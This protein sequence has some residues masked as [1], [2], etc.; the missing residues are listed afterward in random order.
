MNNNNNLETKS[1]LETEVMN[2][3]RSVYIMRNF[4]RPLLVKSVLLCGIIVAISFTV[5]IPDVIKNMSNLSEFA[6]YLSFISAAFI[7]TEFLV[8]IILLAT[9]VLAFLFVKDV[10]KNTN[11]FILKIH[12]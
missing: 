3:V 5:S 11:Y 9:I 1:A 6:Q 10:I 12:A 8:Q 7:K 2:R 4:V